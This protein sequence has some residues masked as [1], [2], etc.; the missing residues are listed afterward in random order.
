MGGAVDPFPFVNR[1]MATLAPLPGQ[2]L[3][4]NIK[5]TGTLRT[6]DSA[7]AANTLLLPLAKDKQY[8][9]VTVKDRLIRVPLKMA[10]AMKE[11]D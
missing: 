2:R 9:I 1:N 3:P 10:K 6:G 7:I 4:D 8:Y 5:L 11:K